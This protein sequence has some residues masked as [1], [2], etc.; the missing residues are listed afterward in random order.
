MGGAG[1]A[2]AGAS[3]AV[4]IMG[5]GSAHGSVLFK[6]PMST[7][8]SESAPAAAVVHSFP[9]RR[10]GDRRRRPT[11]PLSRYSVFGGRRAGERRNGDADTFVDRYGSGTVL[12]VLMVML[13]N[14]LDAV[15]TLFFI[16]EGVARELNPVADILIGMHDQVFIWVKTLGIGVILAFLLVAKNF[17]AA[18][19]GLRVVFSL[20]GLLAL[21][22]MVLLWHYFYMAV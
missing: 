7:S 8:V 3:A 21:Y 17:R 5:Y 10:D 1:A 12:L 19:I 16:R 11:A 22:H 20:Y 18:R 13:F 6:G 15:C 4:R 2:L 9:E 14:A